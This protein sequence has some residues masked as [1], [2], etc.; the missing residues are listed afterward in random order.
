MLKDQN[1]PLAI[2]AQDVPVR[3]KRSVYPEPFASMMAGRE[4]RQL[5]DFF[6]I[7]KFGVNLTSLAPGSRSALLHQH[8]LQEEMVYILEG[9]PSLVTE[10]TSVR[11]SPGMC[12]GFTPHGE[13]HYLLNDTPVEVWYLEIG[14]RVEN[15]K[16][17]YPADDLV[18]VSDE[19]ASWHFTHKDGQP[20]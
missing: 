6:G 14:D 10:K 12:A 9:H 15:D 5:G 8:S 20:Y 3:V 7:K 16:V 19:N 18:A 17:R 4:K 2:I 13:A 11:L 1:H